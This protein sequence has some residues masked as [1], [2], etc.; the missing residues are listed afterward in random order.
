VSVAARIAGGLLT[1]WL[2]GGFF[3][4]FTRAVRERVAGNDTPQFTFYAGPKSSEAGEDDMD[5]LIALREFLNSGEV[6]IG[7]G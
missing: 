6:G 1:G 7:Y 3:I 2:L 4:G 5:M